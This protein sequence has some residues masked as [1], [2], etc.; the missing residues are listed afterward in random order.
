MVESI[1]AALFIIR[2]DVISLCCPKNSVVAFKHGKPYIIPQKCLS[3]PCRRC[4]GEN[5]QQCWADLKRVEQDSAAAKRTS[6][7]A[8]LSLEE[9]TLR[10]DPLLQPSYSHRHLSVPGLRSM[11]RYRHTLQIIL[12]KTSCREKVDP[13]PQS[14]SLCSL[15]KIKLWIGYINVIHVSLH[16]WRLLEAT[17]SSEAWRRRAAL[18]PR[19]RVPSPLRDA[20]IQFLSLLPFFPGTDHLIPRVLQHMA[21]SYPLPGSSGAYNHIQETFY[22]SSALRRPRNKQDQLPAIIHT[23]CWL[24]LLSQGEHTN[25]GW[26]NPKYVSKAILAS[27]RPSLSAA[28]T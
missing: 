13:P 2:L 4:G 22:T 28:T 12:M 21:G 24:T 15:R 17:W 19:R 18:L 7:D 26:L 27:Y 3:A 25:N 6:P 8:Q 23:W 20:P 5:Q 16:G 9:V 11:T 1:R 10:P 14:S